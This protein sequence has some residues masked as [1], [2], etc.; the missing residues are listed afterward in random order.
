MKRKL[1]NLKVVSPCNKEGDAKV[2]IIST[3]RLKMTKKQADK[4][5]DG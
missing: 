3:E 5:T 4:E 2:Q 1:Q